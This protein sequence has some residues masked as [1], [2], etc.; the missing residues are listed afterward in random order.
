MR[1]DS[2]TLNTASSFAEP[3]RQGFDVDFDSLCFS[4]DSCDITETADSAVVVAPKQVELTQDGFDME[5]IS[6]ALGAIRLAAVAL[7]ESLPSLPS[8]SDGCVDCPPVVGS[9][10]GSSVCVA[11]GED[12]EVAALPAAVG[13]CSGGDETG[14]VLCPGGD[15]PGFGLCPGEGV[16]GVVPPPCTLR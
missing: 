10:F 6:A 3:V 5:G 8:A 14:F 9:A 16:T 11:Q 13:P 15:G 12:A 1:R 2:C 4:L 7:S